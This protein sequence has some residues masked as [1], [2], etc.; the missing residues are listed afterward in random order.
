LI[1]N[2][3][4]AEVFINKKVAYYDISGL[5][6]NTLR[7]QM[8]KNGPRNQLSTR[9][10]AMTQWKLS[11]ELDYVDT[12]DGCEVRNVDVTIDIES[13]YPRWLNRDDAHPQVKARW[14]GFYRAL[15]EYEDMH[16]N[17]GIEAAKELEQKLILRS[18]SS[19]RLL[20]N[21]TCEFLQQRANALIQQVMYEYINYDIYLDRTTDYGNGKG[22]WLP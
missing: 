12:N 8:L 4:H 5:T 17:N 13:T 22:V 19:N 10:H 21:Y 14:D 3:A 15:V 20:N 1:A 7:R 9:S 18:E 2:N 16:V 11:S 6:S